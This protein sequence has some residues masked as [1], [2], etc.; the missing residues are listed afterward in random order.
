MNLKQMV[1][2]CSLHIERNFWNKL[3]ELFMKLN[4]NKLILI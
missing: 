2:Y 1:G 3:Y 4:E